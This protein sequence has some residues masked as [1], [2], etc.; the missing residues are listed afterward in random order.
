MNVLL[1]DYQRKNLKTVLQAIDILKSEFN[2]EENQI[3]LGLKMLF[4]NTGLL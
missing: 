4:K 2:I 3:K 1:G